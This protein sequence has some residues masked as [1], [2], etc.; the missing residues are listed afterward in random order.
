M[1]KRKWVT[2]LV[3]L[4]FITGVFATP[5]QGGLVRAAGTAN[6]IEMEIVN[7][8]YG[9]R[10]FLLEMPILITG[11][12]RLYPV[13][14]II[15]SV[16]STATASAD[17]STYTI[18]LGRD[19]VRVT[20]GSTRY[21]V[22]N[23][24]RISTIAPVVY[25]YRSGDMMFF[26]IALLSHFAVQ[27]GGQLIYSGQGTRSASVSQT[28]RVNTVCSHQTAQSGARYHVLVMDVSGSMNGQPMNVAKAA[29]LTFINQA[30]AS[31]GQNYIAIVS[32]ADSATVR[33][34]FTDDYSTLTNAVNKLSAGGN[35]NMV[36][37]LQAAQ[38]LIGNLVGR[39]GSII[40]NVLILSDG[41]PNG[42]ATNNNG[43]FTGLHS[44]G[45]H[46][47]SV[48]DTAYDMMASGINM[49]SLGFFHDLKGKDLEFASYFM[50]YLQ[51]RGF[52]IVTNPDDLE[53]MFDELGSS[54]LTYCQQCVEEAYAA[55]THPGTIVATP[56][57]AP[58]P[59]PAPT[60]DVTARRRVISHL[61]GS[62]LLLNNVTDRTTAVASVRSAIIEFRNWI[63]IPARLHETVAF[64]SEAAI[65][66]AATIYLPDGLYIDVDHQLLF[67]A[68]T[69]AFLTKAAIESLLIESDIHKE[70]D[71]R[72]G[73][74]ITTFHTGVFTIT[75]D[76]SLRAITADYIRID[77][78]DYQIGVSKN[79]FVND[80]KDSP[81]I[82]TVTPVPT[83][84]G[85][86]FNITLNKAVSEG[87]TISLPRA[88]E[89]VRYQTI[90]TSDG[91][92]MN[93]KYNETTGFVE[94][95]VWSSGIYYAAIN[96]V[97]FDDIK[98]LYE[99][100]R[101]SIINLAARGILTERSPGKFAP[102]EKIT[103]AEFTHYLMGALSMIDATADGGFTD[104]EKDEWYFRA[105]SSAKNRGIVTG[106]EDNTFRGE[107]HI[108]RVEFTSIIARTLANEMSYLFPAD[109]D[110]FLSVFNDK[111][112][113]AEWARS[114]V[115]LSVR[116]EV[117]LQ[118]IIDAAE[119][120][121]EREMT[122][123]EA[124]VML[125]NLFDKILF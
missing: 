25:T 35:T 119:F 100:M 108:N 36:S 2:L 54:M 40:P 39:S 50:P 68:Q 60:V 120:L 29:A 59:T 92:N 27:Y 4:V 41:L 67:D 9:G 14:D 34:E 84:D 38:K 5:T 88:G 37:G 44:S 85:K 8:Y 66:R 93:G 28:P 76:A 1:R 122:R 72:S 57:P 55:Q 52:R 19:T 96:E 53:F 75:L 105:A 114:N 51:N 109:P 31:P 30:L 90:F 103:R 111:T 113:I 32:Y 101:L 23:S 13:F 20:L 33:A 125:N 7:V 18:V 112:D 123:G 22:N 80:T 49:W 99:E 6:R 48:Y 81:L 26:P 82:I 79:V 97:D 45:P 74:I 16:G 89:D 77:G 95:R 78:P 110:A 56:T 117:L 104:V 21:Y 98:Y 47:N 43:P 61:S 115:A 17:Y 15:Y 94:T 106:Y 24:E 102:D 62:Y 73:I 63:V 10:S 107:K 121:P 116:D 12:M 65:A 46:A 42:G 11:H 70:R 86:R 124:A 3:L 118:A 69:E 64:F 91:I 71:I 87:I 83:D 58:A